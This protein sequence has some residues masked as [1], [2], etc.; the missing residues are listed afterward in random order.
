MITKI[1]VAQPLP[2]RPTTCQFSFHLRFVQYGPL[3]FRK[4]LKSH[5]RG[6]ALRLLSLVE[7]LDLGIEPDWEVRRFHNCQTRF[8]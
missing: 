2:F 7:I 3:L 6:V 4:A 8:R 1:T 5:G